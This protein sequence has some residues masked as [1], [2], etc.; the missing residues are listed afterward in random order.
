MLRE[1]DILVSYR[2]LP[3][4]LKKANMTEAIPISEEEF[5]AL[6]GTLR[7]VAFDN[8]Y[9]PC[10][11]VQVTGRCNFN[12]LHCF[13]AKDNDPRVSEISMEQM[14]R[15]MDM[16]RD[17][18]ICSVGITGGEPTVHPGIREIIR[19]FAR[20]GVAVKMFFT[21]GY[22]LSQDILDLFRELNQDPLIWVSF[23][24]IGT[25]DV[26]RGIPGAEKAALKALELCIQ[27]GFQTAVNMQVNRKTAGVIGESL[28]ILDAM[29][30]GSTRLIKT[31]ATPRWALNAEG[32]DL[33]FNQYAGICLDIVEQ[34]SKEVHQMR[35]EIWSITGWDPLSTE[36]GWEF[37]GARIRHSY[38]DPEDL[39][40]CAAHKSIAYVGSNGEIY[41]C[42]QMQ[43]ILD[44]RGI[45]FGNVFKDG[46]HNLLQEDSIYFKAKNHTVAEK[47][48]YNQKCG[49]CDYRELCRTGCPLLSMLYHNDMMALDDS[50]CEFYESGF[51]EKVLNLAGC[52]VIDEE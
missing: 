13:A 24:G 25:H 5:S 11:Y 6:K 30:V 4:A 49:K 27:N 36:N 17:C 52:T 29:G 28:R 35:V 41:P 12:C 32:D 7:H 39:P 3:F 2:D 38:E 16:A 46:L 37:P 48:K 47:L 50:T 51:Y 22:L 26:M 15:L 14:T 43:G 23:D 8:M 18:G 40:M 45:S 10:M 33:T 31:T 42:L 19:G 34:Y 20:R 9:M 21:N 1:E 44:S